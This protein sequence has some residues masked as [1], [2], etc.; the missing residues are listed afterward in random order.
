[1]Q[2]PAMDIAKQNRAAAA[3]VFPQL[4]SE[5]NAYWPGLSGIGG[6]LNQAA[7]AQPREQAKQHHTDS[8]HGHSAR[9]RR[10]RVGSADDG[11]RKTHDRYHG[12]GNDSL[13]D[14]T[15]SVAVEQTSAR[16]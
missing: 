3:S 13:V 14:R 4:E 1:M 2:L 7:G 15:S 9:F 5:Q 12:S 11:A 8:E 6:R 16:T 10:A